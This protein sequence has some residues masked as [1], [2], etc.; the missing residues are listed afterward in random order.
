MSATLLMMSSH[1]NH[2]T[3]V[4]KKNV[5]DEGTGAQLR[6]AARQFLH[7]LLLPKVY[8]PVMKL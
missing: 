1:F 3:N 2:S 8:R 6:P 4:N 7:Q 5:I